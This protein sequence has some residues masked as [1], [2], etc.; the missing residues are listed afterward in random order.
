MCVHACVCLCWL[1]FL[2]MGVRE[3]ALCAGVCVCLLLV[4]CV[5]V[6][7]C[8]RVCQ[9]VCSCACV[10]VCLFVRLFMAG[11]FVRVAFDCV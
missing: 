3:Y 6:C 2:R 5:R 8:L 7:V 11:V 10:C 1:A 4:L 9:C